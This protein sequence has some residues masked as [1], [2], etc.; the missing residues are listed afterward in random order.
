M[1][2]RCR[3]GSDAGCKGIKRLLGYPRGC[4]SKKKFFDDFKDVVKMRYFVATRGK[5]LEAIQGEVQILGLTAPRL[6]TCLLLLKFLK[7]VVNK[8]Y[9]AATASSNLAICNVS[10]NGICK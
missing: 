5:D 6:S 4:F 7:G 9:S 8:R 3:K 10:Y 2:L 1:T